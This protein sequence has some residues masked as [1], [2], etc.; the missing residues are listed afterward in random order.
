MWIAPAVAVAGGLILAV[1]SRPNCRLAL[2]ILGVWLAAPW[3]AWWISQPIERA[4]P[5]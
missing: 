4:L 3:I 2:P 5:N 1:C